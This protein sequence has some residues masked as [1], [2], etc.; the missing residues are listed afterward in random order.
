ML[1]RGGLELID[2]DCAIRK[3]GK[4]GF[5]PCFLFVEI[6]LMRLETGRTEAVGAAIGVVEL[7]DEVDGGVCDG[8]DDHLGDSIAVADGIGFSS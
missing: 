1:G 4:H 5:G 8:C 6:V 2:S 7:F 3:H